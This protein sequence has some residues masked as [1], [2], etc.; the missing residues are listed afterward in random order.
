M[1]R[2]TSQRSRFIRKRRYKSACLQALFGQSRQPPRTGVSGM[3][4]RSRQPVAVRLAAWAHRIVRHAPPS[5]Q[6]P[7]AVT[8]RQPRGMSA[9]RP[10]SLP[11]APA[12]GCA[13]PHA[14]TN[15]STTSPRRCHNTMSMPCCCW[16]TKGPISDTNKKRYLWRRSRHRP[17]PLGPISVTF[18]PYTPSR[19]PIARRSQFQKIILP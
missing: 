3:G 18:A 17:R 12:R 7:P 6:T 1:R 4:S 13:D 15:G 2:L 14:T 5:P 9:P 10:R 8:G 16:V 19:R 11:P